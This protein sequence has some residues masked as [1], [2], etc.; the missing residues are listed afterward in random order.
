MSEILLPLGSFVIFAISVSIGYTMRKHHWWKP[1]AVIACIVLLLGYLRYAAQG[2]GWEGIGLVIIGIFAILPAG[3]GL[4]CGVGFGWYKNT[5]KPDTAPTP[6]DHQ[7][8]SE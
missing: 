4:T 7:S 6:G 3:I 1:V 5:R 8:K 2:T